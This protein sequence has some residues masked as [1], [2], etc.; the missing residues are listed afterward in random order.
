MEIVP[1]PS[2]APFAPTIFGNAANE[3]MQ[4][5]SIYINTRYG[6][7]PEQYAKIGFKNHL[8]SVNNPYA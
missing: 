7:K 6:S 2:K 5:Y 1:E 4:K 8:H 3:H